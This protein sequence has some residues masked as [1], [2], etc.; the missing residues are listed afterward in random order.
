[1]V[2]VPDRMKEKYMDGDLR[3]VVLERAEADDAL[4]EQAKLLVMAALEGD[5][6]LEDALGVAPVPRP[7]LGG[8]ATE[9]IRAFLSSITVEGFRGIG[10]RTTLTIAPA[11]GLTVISGRNGCGKSSF[12][13][14]L[15]VALTQGSYRLQDRTAVWHASWRNLHHPETTQVLVELAEEGR[16]ST[17][18]SSSWEPGADLNAASSWTQRDGA[19]QER[20]LDSLGWADDLE[21]FR[22]FLS[23]AELGALFGEDSKLFEALHSI[24]GLERLSDAQKR[25]ETAVKSLSVPKDV[26]AR[27]LKDLK[28][29]LANLVDERAIRALT[30]LRKRQ[31][32]LAAVREL[33]TG[34]ETL[35]DSGELVQLIRIG[36]L[37]GPGGGV[38]NAATK[39]YRSAVEAIHV[40][41]QDGGAAAARR[42]QLLIT[43]LAVHEAEGDGP[44]GVCGVG[45]LDGT[46]A[47]WVR[48]EVAADRSAAQARTAAERELVGARRGLTEL[49][50]PPPPALTAAASDARVV[51]IV[52]ELEALL[53][54]W[55]SWSHLDDPE[56]M[57]DQGEVVLDQ[58]SSTL[59]AVTNR[60][61][62]GLLERQDAWQPLAVRIGAWF[63][64]AE[65]AVQQEASL[66]PAKAALTW[67]KDHAHE[68]RNERL[69]PLA[70][71][72]REIWALLRQESNVELGEITL[73]GSN[74]RRRLLVSASVDGADAGALAVMSQGELNALALSLFLPKATSPDS[75]FGFV[76]I[77]DPVQAMDPARVD[78]LAR[79]LQR[80]AAD[81]QVIVFTHDDRLAEAVRRLRIPARLLEVSRE[82]GSVVSITETETPAARYLDDARAMAS[83]LQLSDD[84]KLRVLPYLCRMAVESQCRDLYFG[85]RLA[86]G[87]RRTDVEDSWNAAT[88]TRSRLALVVHGHPKA[89]LDPWLGA[90]RQRRLA[91]KVC[92]GAP[93]D[94]L[95]SDPHAAIDA[96][97]A[98][99]ADLGGRRGR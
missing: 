67:L 60:A 14:A 37:A 2:E 9:P 16:G 53:Q 20:G 64:D 44:C 41:D 39:R 38:L 47:E 34:A 7:V 87:D 90:S 6:D 13:E 4:P 40:L 73:A 31:P 99:I 85:R 74:T 56:S 25:L 21:L 63:I 98:V 54:A 62:K 80:S 27:Q 8:P 61:R 46:W 77:D 43:A 91:L 17:K 15:E 12:A 50:S 30:L 70:D 89:D 82:V 78:G 83:N 81:R 75:P 88:K 84:V 10:P 76:V 18:V 57:A 19:K 11:P 29:D 51:A 35:D 93:H 68:V 92:S 86:D 28:P 96:V 5:D 94:G 42:T 71:R 48:A 55:S 97:A 95:R 23:Y 26:A 36:E 49:V 45:T 52:P 22:P 66:G 65:R 33:I 59:T 69:R 79:V 32:D 72:A 1:M 58:L 3:S 24:L